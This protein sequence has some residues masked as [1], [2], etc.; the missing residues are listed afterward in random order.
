[1]E[2]ATCAA[3]HRLLCNPE[4]IGSWVVP[5]PHARYL[6]NMRVARHTR[7]SAMVRPGIRH[8]RN[9]PDLEQPVVGEH[10]ERGLRAKGARRQPG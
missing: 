4:K 8:V 9:W 6:C 10:L 7:R 5:R 1:M 3:A 2:R